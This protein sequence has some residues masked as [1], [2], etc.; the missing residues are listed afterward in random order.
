M[1]EN[2]LVL[3]SENFLNDVRVEYVTKSIMSVPIAELSTLGAG[4]AS[5]IPQLNTITQTKA[6]DA[7]GLYTLANAEAGDTLKKAKDGIYWGSFKR[8][9]GSS[10]MLKV[11]SA[12]SR[13]ETTTTTMINPTSMMMA[14]ALYSIEKE[15]GTISEMEKQILSFLETEKE[16]EIEADVETLMRMTEQYKYSWDNEKVVT[17]NHK[18]VIDIQRTARKNMKIY[19]KK[20]ADSLKAKQ[21]TLAQMTV[22]SALGELEKKF[23]Y[24]RLSLYTFALA[25]FMEI[26]LSGNYKEEYIVGIRDEIA[27]MGEEYRELFEKCS[28]YLEKMSGSVVSTNMLKAVG[29]VEKATGKLLGNIPKRGDAV[30]GF[31]QG[32]AANVEDYAVGI[33]QKAVRE[34]AMMNNPGTGLFTSKMN[35]MIQIYNHTTSIYCDEKNIYLKTD[36]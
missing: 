19:Q 4:V 1:G 9:D 33:E 26:M 17:S 21:F 12:D 13:V 34:F 22:D 29:K 28:L 8:A 5:L 16:S 25:S 35:D 31:L 11:Q 24:Y 6:V 10:K 36:R 23:M 30:E 7:S 15:L 20:L 14:V 32:A 18:L 27:G 2:E 3:T